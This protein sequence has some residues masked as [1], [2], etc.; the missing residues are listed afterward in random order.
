M[1]G[2]MNAQEMMDEDTKLSL[3][4]LQAKICKGPGSLIMEQR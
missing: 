1:F 4:Q 2:G 3:S